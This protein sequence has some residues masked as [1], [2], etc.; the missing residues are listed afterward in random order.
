MLKVRRRGRIFCFLPIR[1]GQFW[2]MMKW[3]R[4][5]WH[6]ISMDSSVVYRGGQR[7]ITP[8]PLSPLRGGGGGVLSSSGTNVFTYFCKIILKK[9]FS[10]LLRGQSDPIILTP[11]PPPWRK[12]FIHHH[13]KTVFM[14]QIIYNY[15]ESLQITDTFHGKDSKRFSRQ[16]IA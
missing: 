15:T 6:V 14:R 12:F 11:H 5:W 2:N 10:S 8:P 13:M 16:P 9:Q 7:Y 4:K 3:L 1:T